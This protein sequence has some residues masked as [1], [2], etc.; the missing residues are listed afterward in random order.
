MIH[1]VQIRNDVTLN[2]VRACETGRCKFSVLT[3]K[4]LAFTI[5]APVNIISPTQAVTVQ[6]LSQ[7]VG[8]KMGFR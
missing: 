3:N 1:L 8:A 7:I 5:P 4:S 6:R 2:T